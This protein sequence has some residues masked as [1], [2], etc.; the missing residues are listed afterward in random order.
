MKAMDRPYYVGLL[1]AAGIHGASHQQPQEFQVLTDRPVRSLE[2][3]RARVRF[4]VSK[5][6]TDTAVQSVKTPTGMMCVSTPE[7]TAVD[8]VRFA[9]AAGRLDN[10]ATVLVDL[11][12]LLDP[13]RLLEV[14]RASADLPN[15]QRLGYLLERVRGRPQAKALRE[16]LERQ[17]LRV[18]PLRPGRTA[19]GAAEDLRWHVSIAEPIEVET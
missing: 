5:R 8:L 2:V 6:S 4:F 17:S 7:S 1:S 12:P 9:R 11:A 15:A 16:W 18:I 14:V 19:A 3:G 13:K 10:V